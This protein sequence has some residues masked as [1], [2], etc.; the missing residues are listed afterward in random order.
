MRALADFRRV[1]KI[2]WC[3][4]AI[5]H[6]SQAILPTR[7]TDDTSRATCDAWARRATPVRKSKST[8]GALPTLRIADEVIE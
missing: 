4:L 8:S 5:A 7:K 1:G 2:A 3:D 6:R